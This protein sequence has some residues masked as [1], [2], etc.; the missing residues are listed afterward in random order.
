MNRVGFGN[1][2]QHIRTKMTAWL[3]S[4]VT[5]DALSHFDA[6]YIY[7]NT[8]KYLCYCPIS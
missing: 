1:V 8:S 7:D 6:I 4:E 2:G 3:P 5:N